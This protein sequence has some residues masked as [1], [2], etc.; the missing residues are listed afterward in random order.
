MPGPE[1]ALVSES[2]VTEAPSTTP[3]HSTISTIT[4]RILDCFTFTV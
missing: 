1:G 3:E 2:R 4:I